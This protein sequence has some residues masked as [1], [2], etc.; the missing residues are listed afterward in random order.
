MDTHQ[1]NRPVP[2]PSGNVYFA[3]ATAG[4][5]VLDFALLGERGEDL[6]IGRVSVFGKAYGP[7]VI[8]TEEFEARVPSLIAGCNVV[9]F[10][11]DR[12]GKWLGKNFGVG[13]TITNAQSAYAAIEKSMVNPDI[14]YAA[15]HSLHR[16]TGSARSAREI[17]RAT[18]TVWK[19]V[20]CE[21]YRKLCVEEIGRRE[22]IESRLASAGIESGI[23]KSSQERRAEAFS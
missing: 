13:V 11:S 17:A 6:A 23:S 20:T 10:D 8:S 3:I 16:W 21:R 2:P 12:Y 19:F 5:G 9:V 22:C 15:A 14:Y 7:D 4:A 18:M 1:E